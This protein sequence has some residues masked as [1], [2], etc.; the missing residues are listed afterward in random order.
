M[1]ITGETR[2]LGL[3]GS[4]VSH[5]L[6]PGMHNAAFSRLGLDYV[7]LAF[8]TT[9]ESL[10]GVVAALRD[11]NVKGFNITMPLKKSVMP[12]LDE[13]SPEARMIG[14]VNT[15]ANEGG[16]LIGYN[17]DGK[18]FVRDLK[19]HGVSVRGARIAMAGAGG[20]AR[21]VAIQLAL[22]GAAEVAVFNRTPEKAA[23]IAEAIRKNIPGCKAEAFFLEEGDLVRWLK[24]ADI[25]VNATAL[26][27]HPNEDG[28]VIS[29]PEL[30]RRDLVVSDFIY[31]PTKTKLL[32]IAEEAGCRT[33]NGS[34]ML[35]YQGAE[36]F[37][38]WTGM[39]MP[40]EYVR[41]EV[42]RS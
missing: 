14:C 28:S 9:Q 16:R 26:G 42:F 17:T 11:M 7:Y 27:M 4:P 37:R 21:S 1:K 8:D 20:A 3:L 23:E 35:L 24:D 10:P 29:G 32:R 13:V 41:R 39:D 34:G 2:L 18:G 6:S 5:S 33:L 31:E 12:L 19:E 30:L 25:L 36:A 22:D 40:V 15:V 38:I